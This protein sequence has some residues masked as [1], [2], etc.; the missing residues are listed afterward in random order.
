M[1]VYVDDM[2]TLAMGE[3]RRGG[4]TYKM[5]HLIADTPEELHAMADTIGVNRKWYQG[6]HYDITKSKRLLAIKAGAVAISVRKLAIMAMNRR[7]GFPMG[8]P[9]TCETIAQERRARRN[10]PTGE[11]GGSLPEQPAGE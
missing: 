2:H 4:R 7:A 6:D 8:T 10:L 11:S 1:T 5:S 9:E 3:Y